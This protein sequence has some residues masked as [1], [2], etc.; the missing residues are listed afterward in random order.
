MVAAPTFKFGG[1]EVTDLGLM[2]SNWMIHA[3]EYTAT[4]NGSEFDSKLGSLA[5]A[6][7]SSTLVGYESLTSGLTYGTY[8]PKFTMPADQFATLRTWYGEPTVAGG[9]DL[10]ANLPAAWLSPGQAPVDNSK[11]ASKLLASAPTES[12]GNVV[13]V[14]VSTISP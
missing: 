1:D 2:T 14:P 9:L 5:T 3:M 11:D 7:T 6:A 10:K 13:N 4:S 12:W 8:I